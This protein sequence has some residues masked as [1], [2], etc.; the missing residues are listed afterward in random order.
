M[1]TLPLPEIGHQSYYL[2][3]SANRI[4]LGNNITE[5]VCDR[6]VELTLLEDNGE[7]LLFRIEH[8]QHVTKEVRRLYITITTNFAT[9]IQTCAWP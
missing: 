8:H 5:F 4:L 9:C 1:T 6:L 7:E 2:I 3:S